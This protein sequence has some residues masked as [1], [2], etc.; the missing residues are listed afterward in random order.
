M[1]SEIVVVPRSRIDWDFDERI[2]RQPSGHRDMAT[3]K[4]RPGKAGLCH[5]VVL[6]VVEAFEL[7]QAPAQMVAGLFNRAAV[8]GEHPLAAAEGED[9]PAPG[10]SGRASLVA[11]LAIALSDSSMYASS[12]FA[13]ASGL[14]A[15]WPKLK[16]ASAMHASSPAASATSI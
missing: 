13:S 11:E 6:Q 7:R 1:W 2:D 8:D 16:Y 3:G 14:K 12:T 4:G 9:P 5:G 10:R 15:T